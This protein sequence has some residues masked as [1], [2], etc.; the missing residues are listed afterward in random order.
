MY[1]N[2]TPI[3]P[4]DLIN[5]GAYVGNMMDF[6]NNEEYNEM[7]SVIEKVKDYSIVNRVVPRVN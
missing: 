3:L 5:E 6:V 7:L 4:S 2:S 1:M